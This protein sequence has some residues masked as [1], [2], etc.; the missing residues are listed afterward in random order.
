MARKYD[1]FI[2]FQHEDVMQA[3][4][5]RLLNANPKHQVSFRERSFIDP[6]KNK[7]EAQIK[8]AVKAEIGKSQVVLVLVGRK[9]HESKWVAREVEYA[10]QAGIGVTAQTLPGKDDAPTPKCLKDAGVA[11]EKWNPGGLTRQLHRAVQEG[12]RMGGQQKAP[13][14]KGGCP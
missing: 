9:T 2:S 3:R 7:S 4:G 11:V 14:G 5:L 6:L 13:I 8:A 12:K 10:R 1:T